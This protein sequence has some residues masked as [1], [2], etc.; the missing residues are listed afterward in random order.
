MQCYY[1]VVMS[2]KKVKNSKLP[3][4]LQKI[5][6]N[7]AGIDIGAESHFVCV[8]DGRSETT[9]R[10]FK[11][12]TNDFYKFAYWLLEFK[13]TTVAIESTGVYLIPLYEILEERGIE[14][15]LVNARHV[16]NVPGRKSD[17]LDCQW[18]QQLHTYGLLRGA[19]RPVEQ[20]CTLRAYVRQRAMLVRSAAS[21]I[22]RMQKALAQMNLQ[23]HNV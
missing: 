7:A 23:L 8:P 17:V 16:K 21:Y 3:A 18:L 9:V 6:L 4:E 13:I 20:V 2:K 12:F 5:N 15:K 14:V 11:S 19:F 22:Q 10:E 1:G